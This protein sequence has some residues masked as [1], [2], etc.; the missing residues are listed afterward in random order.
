MQ[1]SKQ[2]KKKKKAKSRSPG[3]RVNVKQRKFKRKGKK[4]P[5]NLKKN[6]LK[7]G[8]TKKIRW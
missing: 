6:Y 8:S 1:Q 3:I 4:T 2:F 7:L 5:I